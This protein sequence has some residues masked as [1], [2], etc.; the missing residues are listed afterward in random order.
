MTFADLSPNAP[1]PEREAW[2][3]FEAQVAD[4]PRPYDGYEQSVFFLG[5][6]PFLDAGFDLPWS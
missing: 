2:V 4:Y 6:L 1:S 3:R 5:I